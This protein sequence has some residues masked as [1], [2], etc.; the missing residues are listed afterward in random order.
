[1][2]YFNAQKLWKT[3]EEL[4]VISPERL[5][6]LYQL[7]QDQHVSFVEILL[8]HDA[9][10]E[11]NLGRLL[12]DLTDY[13]YARLSERSIDKEVLKI[14]PELV[15]QKQQVIAFATDKEG[16]H[17]A[18]NDPG[19]VQMREFLEKK[20]GLP[21]ISYIAFT[22]EIRDA[23]GLYAQDINKVFDKI[24]EQNVEEAVTAQEADPPIITIVNNLIEYAYRNKASDIHLEPLDEK[25]TVRFRIDG[26]LHDVV[27]LPQKLHKRIITRVK[28]MASLRIDEHQAAQDGKIHYEAGEIEIDLRVSVVPVVDGEQVVMRLLSE[29]S[30]QHSLED[31]GLVDE[32]LEKVK[33]AYQQPH[34]MILATGRTG[35]GK[36]TTLYAILKLLNKHSVNI[37]TIEDPVEYDIARINQ[38]QINAKTDLTFAKGLRSIVRQDPDIILV[39]E[40]R[41]DETAEIA[42]NSAMTGHLVLST[43][44]TNDA[45]TT[46]PRLIDLKVEPFLVASTVNVIIAQSLVRRICANCRV[47]VDK[48]QKNLDLLPKYLRE[49]YFTDKKV[50]L[51]EGKGCDVCHQSGY[52]GRLGIFEVMVINDK[53]REVIT[54]QQN[55][56]E[57]KQL[58]IK[59]GMTT[60]ME[61]GLKK[62]TQGLTTLE[63]VLRV[64]K[65]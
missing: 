34:G 37:M 19:D 12:S 51:Y 14:I 54:E 22:N 46:I 65:E 55:A 64:A 4:E 10:T 40:I 18:M 7:S 2:P 63:E 20:T 53:L 1:M 35:S 60:M 56:E 29:R 6:E 3:L 36:T 38:I 39:G 57:I 42:I 33:K 43:L 47:S 23:L 28:V 62:I 59:H 44:H 26:V 45:A 17:V 41:D 32:D 15:A 31:L 11:K 24:I 16:L 27:D 13:Q 25:T 8:Q 48:T 58:A 50:Q 5:A 52:D 49:K 61:D 21:V 9:V 30:R